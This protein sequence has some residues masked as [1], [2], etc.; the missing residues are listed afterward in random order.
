MRGF[1]DNPVEPNDSVIVVQI[2][3]IASKSGG[4]SYKSR[5]GTLGFSDAK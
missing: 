1:P 3:S 4:G 2:S 5:G